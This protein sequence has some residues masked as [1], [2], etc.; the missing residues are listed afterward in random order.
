MKI[1]LMVFD[2][3][4]IITVL[5]FVVL[6]IFI[7]I[8]TFKENFSEIIMEPSRKK[9]VFA[10]FWQDETKRKSLSALAGE[11]KKQNPDISV[12]LRDYSYDDM[13]KMLLS[14]YFEGKMDRKTQEFFY[15]DV[16]ALDPRWL[17]AMIENETLEKLTDYMEDAAFSNTSNEFADW[18]I[19][20]ISSIDI[21]FYDVE[22]LKAMGFDRPPKNW[23]DFK[24][25]AR[26]LS[27]PGHYGFTLSLSTEDGHYPE[28]YP[29]IW[30]SGALTLK[31]GVNLLNLTGFIAAP[32]SGAAPQRTFAEQSQYTGTIAW[33]TNDN[34][35]FTG[36][37]FTANTAYKAVVTL[38]AKSGFTFTGVK[39][40]AF[41][42]TG[43]SATNAADSGTVTI[44]F[45]ATGNKA[46]VVTPQAVIEENGVSADF[47]KKPVIETLS[48]I[49]E[50]KQEGLISSPSKTK[51]QKLK[52]FISGKAV[53]MIASADDISQIRKEKK[54]D[55]GVSTIPYPDNYSGKPVF[56]VTG[57][58]MGINKM[59]K[60]KNDAF[61]FIAFLAG[62][63][64]TLAESSYSIP[65]NGNTP[66]GLDKN[67]YYAKAYDMYEGGE[68]AQE[69]TGI[70]ASETL[71]AIVRDEVTAMLAGTQNPEKTAEIIEERWKKV[72]EK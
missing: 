8:F 26:V 61:A 33:K 37:T 2:K 18:A 64:P 71:D 12:E 20:L 53:M 46:L 1:K 25:Y 72:L 42:Y 7:K 50:L 38:T 60:R 21:F 30:A 47:N 17:S 29:W 6:T 32:V 31:H 10:Y 19:P 39:E 58:S 56:G 66:S 14:P 16:F 43:A 68:T 51:T 35:A 22:A 3:I 27:N 24:K 63:S 48:F 23:S 55:F 54:T 59:S 65:G 44:S 57:V 9:L 5:I 41:R 62:H 49:N 4:L 69:F 11:F 40:D 70:A 52:E 45:P 34:S 13:R 28:I 36:N 15:A 67:P